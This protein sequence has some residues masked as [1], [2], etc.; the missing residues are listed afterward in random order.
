MT[1]RPLDRLQLLR[2]DEQCARVET[3]TVP[4]AERAYSPDIPRCAC[5]SR[6][7]RVGNT[8]CSRCGQRRRDRTRPRR[9]QDNAAQMEAENGSQ[10]KQ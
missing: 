8:L 1:L 6:I 4:W 10:E 2:A 3:L 5:G 9:G 7:Y